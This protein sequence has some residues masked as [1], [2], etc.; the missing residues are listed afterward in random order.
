M[1]G[2]QNNLKVNGNNRNQPRV[3]QTGQTKSA[4]VANTSFNTHY[5]L[6]RNA[7]IEMWTSSSIAYI[8]MFGLWCLTPLSTIFQSYRGGQFY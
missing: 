3:L 2:K 6:F 1:I 8:S 4:K 7:G 5:T